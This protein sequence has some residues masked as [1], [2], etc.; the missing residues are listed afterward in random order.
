MTTPNDDFIG[1]FKEQP[2]ISSRI[3]VEKGEVL[4][5]MGRQRDNLVGEAKP[6]P[7]TI[8]A[9]RPQRI[10]HR[11][12]ISILTDDEVCEFGLAED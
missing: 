2:P 7:S 9:C 5:P 8:P 3:S 10:K 6:L 12:D 1:R 11:K 4:S